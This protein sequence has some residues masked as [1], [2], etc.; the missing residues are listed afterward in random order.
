MALIFGVAASDGL[1][2]CVGLEPENIR[3]IQDGKPFR[4][5]YPT[6]PPV[7]VLIFEATDKGRVLEKLR[8]AGVV[9]ENTTIH[10][11]DLGADD[12]G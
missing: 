11:R 6:D 9:D 2:V 7:E 5:T 3:R 10:R 1:L 4:G 12:D 8:E